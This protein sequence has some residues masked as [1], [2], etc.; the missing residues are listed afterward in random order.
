MTIW[1]PGSRI[2]DFG[3]NK[4]V[5]TWITQIPNPRSQIRNREMSSQNPNEIWQVEVGGQIYEAPF[6]ELGEWI[7]E[8]SLQPGDK[9][10]RGNLRWVEAR[11]VP[12]LIPFF[13]AKQQGKPIPVVVST[14]EAPVASTAVPDSVVIHGGQA[15]NV[16]RVAST[17]V[18]HTIAAPSVQTQTSVGP[19]FCAAHADLPS[20]FLCDGCG[21]GFC[22]VCPKAYGA[23]VRICPRCGGMCRTRSEVAQKQADTQRRSAAIKEGFGA[24]DF[25]NALT[26]P[27][28]F[29]PSLVFGALMFMAFSLGQSAMSVGGIYMMVSAIFCMMLA[30]MLTFGV[31]ANTVDSFARGNLDNNF[32]PAFEDFDI[33]ENV[34]H[35]FF[36]SIGAYLSSFG[37]FFLVML[38]GLYMITSSVTSQMQTFEEKLKKTPGT[39][40]FDTKRAVDQSEEVKKLLGNMSN[41]Q[42][43]KAQAFEDEIRNAEEEAAGEADVTESAATEPEETENVAVREM[44]EQEELWAMMQESRKQSLESVVG[45][46][47]DA[48]AKE[49]QAMLQSFLSLAAP[50]VVIGAI[51]FLWGLFYF[52]AACLVAGYTRSFAATINPVVGLDTIRRLGGTYVKILLMGLVLLIIS[53]IVAWIAGIVLSPFELPRLGNLPAEAIGALVGF[54]LWVVFSCILGYALFKRSNKLDLLT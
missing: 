36:L 31:L 33:W 48:E 14:T 16:P 10:R 43:E 3:L 18:E 4:Y 12:G 29:K 53:A 22:K 39:P 25:F 26:H 52:P 28:N 30:N 13:N 27:F 51:L 15:S 19:D 23:S 8:G 34:V 7:G 9:V 6:A 11:L 41:R 46:T 45:K 1:D 47:P 17:P 35:P 24:V 2:L 40:A 5:P 38:I 49:T 32:M 54:Y 42:K 20:V 44:R 50:L 21:N 37:P